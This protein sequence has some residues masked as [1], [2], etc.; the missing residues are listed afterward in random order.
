MAYILDK[1]HLFKQ[2][3]LGL[4]GRVENFHRAFPDSKLSVRTLRKIYKDNGIKQ[5]VLR[6][7]YALT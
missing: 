5:R 4:I 7:D 1:E 6:V 2:G 3:T